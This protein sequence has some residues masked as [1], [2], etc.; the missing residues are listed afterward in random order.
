MG[1][2]QNSFNG[3]SKKKLEGESTW[4]KDP[5]QILDNDEPHFSSLTETDGAQDIAD[6]APSP[7]T[8]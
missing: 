8:L 3:S 7:V 5:A 6:W 4:I 1:S 2:C